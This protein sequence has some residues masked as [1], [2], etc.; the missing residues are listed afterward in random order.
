[1]VITPKHGSAS[2]PRPRDT[3]PAA[4]TDLPEPQPRVGET[5]LIR[6]PGVGGTG[7]VTAS[8]ILQMAAHLQGLH[9]AALE[10]TGLAQ[11]GGRVISDIRISPDPVRGQ[12]RATAHGVDVLIGLDLLGAA[13]QTTIGTLA[14]NRT[15]AVLN[16]DITPTAAMVTD[17]EAPAPAAERL[18]ARI[19]R[20]SRSSDLLTIPADTLSPPAMHARWHTSP[21]SST[22][23]W[24]TSAPA[25]PKPTLVVSSS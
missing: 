24:A 19:R 7:V 23:G 21:S 16:A 5:V 18:L 6:M 25:S 14:R 17:P 10:Q 2:A 11:K 4:P 8:A 9:A 3:A 15:V 12:V 20:R 22:A 13:D 1:M